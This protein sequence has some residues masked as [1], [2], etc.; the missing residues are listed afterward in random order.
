MDLEYPK[1][2]HEEYKSYPLA[3]GKKIIE[4][5]LMSVYQK[6]LMEDLNLDPPKGEKIVLTL[7]DKTNYVVH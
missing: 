2:L 6:C 5:E 1:E 3:P 4:K 7:E